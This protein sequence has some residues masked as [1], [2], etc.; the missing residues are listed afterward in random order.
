MIE[1][2]QHAYVRDLARRVA[3]IANTPEMDAKRKRWSDAYML[4]EQDRVPI[5]CRPTGCRVELLPET[6]LKCTDPFLRTAENQ[7]RWTLLCHELGDDAIVLPYWRVPAAIEC[8]NPPVWGVE[9]KR[10][11]STEERG[12]WAFDPPIKTEADLDKLVSPQWRH[13]ESETQ[14]RL[15]QAE[16]LLGDIIPVRFMARCPLGASLGAI[17]SQLIGL[18]ALMLNVALKPDMMHRLMAFLRDGVLSAMDHLEPMGVLT[19]NNDEQIHFSECLKTSPADAP[20]KFSDLWIRTE[21]QEFQL[22]GPDMWREFLLDYQMPILERYRYVSYGCCE[23]LTKKID[24]VLSIPNLRIF[25]NSPWTD[26][27]TA[28]EKCRGR[29]CIAWRQKAT[30]VIFADDL[31]EVRARLEEGLRL[32]QGCNRVIVLQEVMTTN[33]NPGRLKDWTAMAK[34]ASERLS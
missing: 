8:V 27:A 28:A 23:D 34:D 9:T 12:A 29:A 16:Y 4:R 7:L 15:E 18:D 19:E 32:T 31:S 20:V 21:S 26:M 5:W 30:D 11:P 13:N 6:A 2:E 10:V 24:G 25:V 33:G 1:S 14:Q 3:E 17:A 22:I